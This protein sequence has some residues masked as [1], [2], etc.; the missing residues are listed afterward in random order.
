VTGIALL[1]GVVRK[2]LLLIMLASLLGTANFAAVLTP[3]QM[4]VITIV[5]VFYIPCIATIAVLAK[6]YGFKNTL[7]IT[8]FEI[9]FAVVLGG[10]T[11]RVLSL[12]M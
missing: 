6:E 3:V 9:A 8:L 10:L 2:E 7:F 4:I 12:F 11:Y 1:F 5:A